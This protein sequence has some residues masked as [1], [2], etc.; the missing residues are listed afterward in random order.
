MMMASVVGAS[1][2]THLTDFPPVVEVRG[3]LKQTDN[4]SRVALMLGA[5]PVAF[6]RSRAVTVFSL[7]AEGGQ[8]SVWAEC[9]RARA[10]SR[11]THTNRSPHQ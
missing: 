8:L 10:Q 11:A 4:L 2:L 3:L 7:G 5:R 6:D 9:M 1:L